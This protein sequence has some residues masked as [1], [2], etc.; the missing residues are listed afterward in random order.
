MIYIKKIF[1]DLSIVFFK[2]FLE[3]NLANL[4]L[5]NKQRND[6]FRRYFL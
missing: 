3:L 2:I 4:L 6:Q 5:P 1:L